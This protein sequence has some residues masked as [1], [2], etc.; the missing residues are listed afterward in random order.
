MSLSYLTWILQIDEVS[1]IWFRSEIILIWEIFNADEF[2]MELG[3]LILEDS[4]LLGGTYSRNYF[5]IGLGISATLYPFNL[6]GNNFLQLEDLKAGDQEISVG[7]NVGLY[8]TKPSFPDL[9]R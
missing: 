4:C 2:E 7:T 3:H 5:Y 6:S 9:R 8:Y 1:G